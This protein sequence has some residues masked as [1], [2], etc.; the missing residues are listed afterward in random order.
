MNQDAERQQP[1][2]VL[3][4]FTTLLVVLFIIKDIELV[5][6]VDGMKKKLNTQKL[7]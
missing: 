6:V 7:D 5:L 1:E 2:E 4:I 3:F